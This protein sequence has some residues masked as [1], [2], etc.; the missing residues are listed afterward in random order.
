LLIGK[1]KRVTLHAP[2]I[3]R[4]AWQPPASQTRCPYLLVSQGPKTTYKQISGVKRKV[5]AVITGNFATR[6]AI[7]HTASIARNADE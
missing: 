6:Q 2:A 1:G 7:N 4:S 5:V 3:L